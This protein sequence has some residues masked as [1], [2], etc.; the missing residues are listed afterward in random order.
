ME[1][2]GAPTLPPELESAEPQAGRVHVRTQASG[3]AAIVV[4]VLATLMWLVVNSQ[5][6]M[7]LTAGLVFAVV[8]DAWC[9][10]RALSGP[11][12]KVEATHDAVAGEPITWTLETVRF[13]QP[14]AVRSAGD[15]RGEATLVTRG[16]PTSFELPDPGRGIVHFVDLDLTALGPI[17]LCRAARRVRAVPETPRVVGPAPSVEAPGSPPPAGLLIDLSAVAPRGDEQFRGVRP[18]QRGDERRKV[19]WKATARHGRTMVREEDGTSA[20]AL[21]VV[22]DL[23]SNGR[24]EASSDSVEAAVG[25]A[26]R[27]VE[28]ALRQG[29][30]VQLVTRDATPNPP[31]PV[32][33]GSPFRSFRPSA[34]R[35]TVVEGDVVQVVHGSAAVRRQLA[36]AT[37][38]PV[39]APAWNGLRCRVTPGGVSWS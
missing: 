26:A 21:Q 31:P 10:Y 4:A 8:V 9:A 14:F 2:P 5:A 32:A 17:G 6:L 19:H 13:V 3:K 34:R 18:Y 24:A 12:P 30:V 22:V 39:V 1:H 15:R 16:G 37:T 28:D 20:V 36:T 23:G 27:V 29:W 7:T 25:R 33:L 11:V 35:G 38:G